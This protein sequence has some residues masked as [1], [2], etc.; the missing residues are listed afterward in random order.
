M[1]GGSARR[2]AKRSEVAGILLLLLV[3]PFQF[4]DVFA[5]V[6]QLSCSRPVIEFQEQ[7]IDA[8]GAPKVDANRQPVWQPAVAQGNDGQV[9]QLTSDYF[10][11]SAAARPQAGK[12]GQYALQINLND[13]GAKLAQQISRR[14]LGRSLA[15]FSDGHLF[16]T[17]VVASPFSATLTIQGLTQEEAQSLAARINAPAGS[18]S[19]S[20]TSLPATSSQS[21]SLPMAGSGGSSREDGPL[22][23]VVAASTA[24]L[25]GAVAW[26]VGSRRRAKQ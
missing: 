18:C 25:T 16:K 7:Q 1:K 3:I 6:E 20:P 13:E 9:H 10:E 5:D 4:T 12:G 17:I 24:G 15:L 14:N 23:A 22:V 26:L 2:W 8:Q 19:A 21:Q 11:P